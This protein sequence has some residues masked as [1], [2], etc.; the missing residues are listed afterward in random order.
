MPTLDG[1]GDARRA[2]EAALDAELDKGD[3]IS[4]VFGE[5]PGTGRGLEGEEPWRS[6]GMVLQVWTLCRYFRPLIRLL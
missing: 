4:E 5:E 6:R 3:L 2:V 1:T